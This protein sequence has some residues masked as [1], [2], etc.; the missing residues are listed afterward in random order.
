MIRLPLP[1][2]WVLFVVFLAYTAYPLTVE[3]KGHTKQ[4]ASQTASD[5]DIKVING[6]IDVM[7]ESLQKQDLAAFKTNCA[8]DW[9]LY[10]ARG[11][12][13]SADDLFKM[14]KANV[15]DFKLVSSQVQIH[16]S[17][18]TAWATYDAEMSGQIKG[19]PW[20]GSFIFT[21]IFQKKNGSW[22]CVHMHESKKNEG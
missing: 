1:E 18:D 12:K 15:R 19:N 22:V 3:G 21:N 7:W 9:H 4:I 13:L 6:L 17:G 10:T 8:E 11:I 2:F 5:E 14:H 20:G 16:I